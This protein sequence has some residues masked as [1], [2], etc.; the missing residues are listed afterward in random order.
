VLF[1]F[2]R[3]CQ[4]VARSSEVRPV[5]RHRKCRNAHPAQVSCDANRPLIWQRS[6]NGVDATNDCRDGSPIAGTVSWCP[7][8]LGDITDQRVMRINEMP[9]IDVF[10]VPSNVSAQRSR[11]DDSR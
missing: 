8:N 10:P 4:I 5:H 11:L 9:Q 7:A 1:L 6:G 2:L 3:H